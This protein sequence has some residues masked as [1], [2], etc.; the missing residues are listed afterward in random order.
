ME[1]A[2]GAFIIFL[3]DTRRHNFHDAPR[4]HFSLPLNCG[5]PRT[6]STTLAEMART[7]MQHR[8]K[9]GAPYALVEFHVGD[10]RLATPV[11]VEPA[12]FDKLGVRHDAANHQRRH[13][14]P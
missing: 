2:A 9:A 10:N 8:E 6:R 11:H 5:P 4:L 7:E 14:R 13:H 3:S 12:V 1:C